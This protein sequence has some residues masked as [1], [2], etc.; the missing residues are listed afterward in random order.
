M[1]RKSRA[2]TCSIFV[3]AQNSR[4]ADAGGADWAKTMKTFEINPNSPLIEGL[5]RR[6]EQL[7]TDGESDVELE[8]E[9]KE[10]TSILIDSA[11]VRSGFEVADPNA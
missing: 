2:V 1:Y 11:L 7:P 6:V 3:E 9:L 4:N 5:L 8:E 10:V